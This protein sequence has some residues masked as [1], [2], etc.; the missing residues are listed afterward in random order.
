MGAAS[1]PQ[2]AFTVDLEEW[3]HVCGVAALERAHWDQLPSRVELTTRRL[4]DLLDQARIRATF[5]VVGWVAARHPRLVEDIRHAG[6]EIGSHS[7]YHR[8]VYELDADQ[9]RSDLRASVEALG[10]GGSA[11]VALFRA[12]EWS[13]HHGSIWALDVLASE[14]FTLDASMAPLRLVGDPAFP[15]HPHYR[16]TVAGPIREVPPL[17]ADR[18]GQVMPIGWG[19]GLR[20]SSPKR[21][22]RTLE[23]ELRAGRAAVITIHP[24]EIDPDPPRIALPPRL[25]FAHYF[26]LDGF[27][28]RLRRILAS[29]MP[30][31]PISAV[32]VP[33]EVV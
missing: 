27:F 6:H 30:F 31:G 2:H 33:G 21:V 20:M 3:F 11:P 1:P 5:F 28:D 8:R 19:W 16:Q 4:L 18:F 23:A 15:R 12:P 26:R 29:G 22:L 7:F 13:I 14:G 24:W 25:H 17:V 9:F 32:P 10:A